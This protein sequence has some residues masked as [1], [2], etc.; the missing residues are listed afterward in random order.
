MPIYEYACECGSKFDRYLSFDDY[1][2]PQTC[3]CGKTASKVLSLPHVFVKQSISYDS[4]IDGR[5]ITNARERKED[6]ARSGCV[7]YDPGVKQDYQRRIQREEQ[8]LDKSVDESVDAAISKM[9]ARKLEQ[10]ESE[11]KS[12]LNPEVERI[13]PS[14]TSRS[15]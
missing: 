7:E 6:L 15:N 13:T 4:P 12:G 11:L 2:I 9:P 10:L 8:E 1:L 5:H 14:Q 3:E